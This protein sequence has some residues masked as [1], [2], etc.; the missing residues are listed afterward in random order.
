MCL[1]GGKKMV[2]QARFQDVVEGWSSPCGHT[3]PPQ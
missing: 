3:T 1:Q 2:L